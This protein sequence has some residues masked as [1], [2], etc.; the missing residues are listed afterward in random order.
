MDSGRGRGRQERRQ[1]DWDRY[2]Q[3]GVPK[4][5]IVIDSDSED[6]AAP[7]PSRHQGYAG[8]NGANDGSNRHADKKRKTAPTA[9]YDPVYNNKASNSTT[10]TDTPY[11][12][13][14]SHSISTGVNN[15]GLTAA[16]SIA[17][18]PS[19]GHQASS[20]D[21]GVVGQKRKRTRAAVQD[22]AK[23]REL[24]NDQ[25]PLA[26]YHPPPN[27]PRKAGDVNV[28]VVKDVRIFSVFVE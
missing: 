6:Q 7:P 18:Q 20:L 25:D 27:P 8:T 9:A 3:N 13:S 22:E 5:I 16:S 28:V 11:W 10:T 17:S 14:G 26:H 21:G 4:E 12:E 15:P 23:R 24:E 2:Y 19:A 1:P